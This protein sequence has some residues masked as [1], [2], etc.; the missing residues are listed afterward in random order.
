MNMLRPALLALGLLLP[1]LDALAQALPPA[2]PTQPGAPPA[3]PLAPIAAPRATVESVPMAR[4]IP[5][6]LEAGGGRVLQ[7]PAPAGSVFAADPRVAEVRP[8]SAVSLFVFGV[9]PG[10]T[11]IA[12][13]DASG[14]AVA[15]YDVT[16]RPSSFGAGEAQGALRRLLPGRDVRV[17]TRA[18]GLVATGEVQTPAEANLVM[19]TLRSYV[20]EDQ[21][22]DNRLSV[23][24]STQVNLRVR[25]AEVSREV[26]RQFGINWQALG[27]IGRFGIAAATNTAL[28]D[29]LNLA[30]VVAGAYRGA[31]NV[32]AVIEALA[33]DRLITILAE[34]NLVAISGET[35]S[36]LVG[37]E[38]PIPVG[39][40]NGQ[41]TIEF[42]QYG[43]SLAFVPTVLSAERIV[44]RVRPE[45][46]ELSEQGAVR[47]TANNQSIQVPGLT[48]RR[49][50][51]TVELGSGQSFAIAGLLQ[52]TSRTLGRALPYV[53]E[54]PVLGA[55][56][57]SDRYQRNETELVI[58]VTPYVVRPGSSPESVR[59]PIDGYL[60]PT[61]A[62][63]ILLQRQ[64]GVPSRAVPSVSLP[65]RPLQP[66][67]VAGF[68]IF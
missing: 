48:V 52:D 17:E 53:G 32:D 28:I 29:P 26:T 7:L 1:G 8:A 54:I 3:R 66:P 49:A 63:R 12:A 21:R 56:F 65:V 45:V 60:P 27:Q 30:S 14:A 10:R 19:S 13:L 51:T 42:K 38:F 34:P 9:A 41:V 6:A 57:R 59:T 64:I 37:G 25:I 15:T 35:A 39:Q 58:V 55:L 67:G 22:V 46:S 24:A 44:M 31:V 16:V 5:L 61:D 2:L 50:E 11:T 4:G 40:Q 47:L 18:N 20:G 43:I 62:E 68:V 36:F 23:L 33:Q